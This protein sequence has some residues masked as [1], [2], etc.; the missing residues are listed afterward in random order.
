LKLKVSYKDRSG[1]EDSDEAE[2]ELDETVPDFY[3]NTGIHKAILLSRYAD[4][5]KDW[6]VDERSGLEAGKVMPTVTLESGI[7]I[8]IELGE[9][10]RQSLPLQVSE[11]YRKLFALYAP[12]FKKERK[13]IGDGN[14][15]REEVVLWK[16]SSFENS[17]QAAG[18]LS[19]IKAG[20]HQAYNKVRELS[21]G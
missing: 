7:A 19:S 5:L 11:P 18:Y 12:Y 16:L 14:L 15:Q 9:W 10:E 20:I 1:R 17:G 2:V 4:L 6:I 3:K 13:A 8:P 21:K